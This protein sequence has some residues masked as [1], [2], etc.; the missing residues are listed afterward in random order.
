MSLKHQAARLVCSL[1]VSAATLVPGFSLAVGEGENATRIK[2]LAEIRGVRA[3]QLVGLG[4]VV[5]LPGTGDSKASLAT[6]KAVANMLSRL[7]QT[8]SANEVITKNIAAVVVTS[9]LPPFARIGDR[10]AVRISSIG[11]AASLEGGTLLLTPLSAA[12]D[13]VYAVAQGSVSSGNAMAGIQGG[14]GGAKNEAPKTV[15]MAGGATVEREFDQAFVHEGKLELSLKQSDFTT[16]TRVSQAINEYF[17]EFIADAENA[18]LIRVRVPVSAQGNKSFPPVA[19][20]A[21]LEQIRVEPDSR[22]LVIVNERTGTVISGTNVS[23]GPIAISHGNLEIVVQKKS[24]Y[25]GAVPAT[26][27]VG[28]LVG[29]LNALGAGPKDLIAILQALDAAKALRAELKML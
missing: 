5:G 10:L 19:F 4:L 25:V 29:A 28:D 17:G 9:D 7:G 12:D 24:G 22:A 8:V 23:I 13:Q 14:A 1:V 18:G 21:A 11:D 15:A 27:T 20:V 2:D 26:T 16:A 6:N 3:N